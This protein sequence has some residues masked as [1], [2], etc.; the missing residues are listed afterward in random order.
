MTPVGQRP[1]IKNVG[2]VLPPPALTFNNASVEIR[3]RQPCM[4]APKAT[5]GLVSNIRGTI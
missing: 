4:W 5:N 3:V 2:T 1:S